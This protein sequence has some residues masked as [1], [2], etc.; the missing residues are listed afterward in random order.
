MT[1][2]YA[3]NQNTAFC[4]PWV[5]PLRYIVAVQNI[6]AAKSIPKVKLHKYSGS[7]SDMT[8]TNIGKMCRLNACQRVKMLT[9]PYIKALKKYN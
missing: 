8:M 2:R 3:I 5:F 1:S 9:N 6:C 4:R 7:V